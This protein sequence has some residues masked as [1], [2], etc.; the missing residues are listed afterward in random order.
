MEA[1]AADQAGARS[2]KIAKI[3]EIEPKKISDQC[4]SVARVL[5]S[6]STGHPDLVPPV[7]I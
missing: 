2:A 4:L 1:S 7:T 5:L 3:A 6:R